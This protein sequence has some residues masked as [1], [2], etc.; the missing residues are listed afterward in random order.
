MLMQ[1]QAYTSAQ[2][3]CRQLLARAPND[4]NARHLL[5]VI[6]LRS[7]NPLAACKE[8]KHAASLPVAPRFKAQALSNLSLA[9]QQRERIEEALE[10]IDQA[11]ALAPQEHAFLLNRLNLLESLEQWQTISETATRHPELERLPDAQYLLARAERKQGNLVG[12]LARL[13]PARKTLPDDPELECE[14]AL[15]MVL[16]GKE[17]ELP[18]EIREHD[19]RDLQALADYMAEEGETQAALPIYR[20]LLER[21]PDHAEARHMVA[22]AQGRIEP[23]A[24]ADY[25]RD[26]YDAHAEGFEQQL[27][28][29]LEYRAPELLAERLL[30]LLPQK[31]SRVADL[32]CGSGLLGRALRDRF[33]ID[34][35][36]GCDLSSG[37]LAQAERL[38]GYD[39][40]DRQEL[41]AWL[42]RHAEIELICATDVLIYTGDL[43]PV[44]QAVQRSLKPGGWFAFSTEESVEDNTKALADEVQLDT[45]GRYRHSKAHIRSR[46]QSAN[47]AVLHCEHFPLR[48]ERGKMVTGLMVICRR[49]EQP[50]SETAS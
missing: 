46:A 21:N 47:L 13:H 40:L 34:Y 14:W 30:P 48:R 2:A 45:S 20:L 11:L 17:Q 28:G 7:G 26:L 25:I 49:P 50:G 1:Q 35:L 6:K 38:G 15:L 19:D 24:P 33:S 16:N 10:A 39:R 44:M 29:R 22:A 37:M 3:I 9:L 5:G 8:L 36:T 32:G 23:N 42:D 31:L 43:T 12:A 27:V 4:F 41:L 18:A